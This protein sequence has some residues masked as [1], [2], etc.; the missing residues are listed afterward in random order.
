M[1]T[2]AKDKFNWKNQCIFV[3]TGP[4]CTDKF[5]Q[6]TYEFMTL[7]DNQDS[8]PS[9]FMKFV[10]IHPRGIHT[11]S[12][13][14]L[15]LYTHLCYDVNQ[16]WNY[17]AKEGFKF[18]PGGLYEVLYSEKNVILAFP[19]SIP[20]PAH[21]SQNI[22]QNTVGFDSTNEPEFMSTQDIE[23]LLRGL[24][25]L[26]Y[27][28][29]LELFHKRT[30]PY[31]CLYNELSKESQLRN[32][33]Q[34]SDSIDA[35]LTY[36]FGT[37]ACS[38]PISKTDISKFYKEIYI[39][40][41]R[42]VPQ[43]ARMHIRNGIVGKPSLRS[44]A[45]RAGE[46]FQYAFDIPRARRA[47]RYAVHSVR[48]MHKVLQNASSLITFI[49]PMICFCYFLFLFFKNDPKMT[50]TL[51]GGNG[52]YAAAVEILLSTQ[53]A[54]GLI[55]VCELW[56]NSWQSSNPVNAVV[57]ASRSIVLLVT[58]FLEAFLPKLNDIWQMVVG[59]SK[60]EI[61]SNIVG[62]QQTISKHALVA[63]S[64]FIALRWPF[65]VLQN[66]GTSLNKS[67]AFSVYSSSKSFT[68]N[69]AIACIL[70]LRGQT[71]ELTLRFIEFMCHI[72]GYSDC[73]AKANKYRSLLRIVLPFL[74]GYHLIVGQLLVFLQTE[75]SDYVQTLWSHGATRLFWKKCG[76]T[77]ITPIKLHSDIQKDKESV[78]FLYS[79]GRHQT[80]IKEH[81]KLIQKEAEAERNFIDNNNESG[82]NIEKLRQNLP[83]YKNA[84]KK[85]ATDHATIYDAAHLISDTVGA[86]MNKVGETM[87]NVSNDV[88]DKVKNISFDDSV[89]NIY[90][91]L[92]KIQDKSSEILGPFVGDTVARGIA[93]LVGPQFA[94]A[95]EISRIL[96]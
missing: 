91:D 14:T 12:N 83:E 19:H 7:L 54:R 74:F 39:A 90:E 47:V 51:E 85:A 23:T 76:M 8:L 34:T 59:L 16:V 24:F 1:I 22:C 72:A 43:A 92:G 45:A 29:T 6:M 25:S 53:A 84:I 10:S 48:N 5:K 58:Q 68:I 42:L 44:G 88:I 78:A 87:N 67:L 27:V 21:K 86:T 57:V 79:S 66:L 61:L 69:L 31:E 64:S 30:T 96:S 50:I 38:H 70:A 71:L 62:S 75:A 46:A 2:L 55:T 73:D 56:K 28:E 63:L 17:L 40:R 3:S 77:A 95:K 18:P 49:R 82:A 89:N 13:S 4:S 11:K 94:V 20:N 36:M 33:I 32:T 41:K 60:F 81:E 26:L 15:Q 80:A 65:D 9:H 35:R 93:T 37:N 52:V